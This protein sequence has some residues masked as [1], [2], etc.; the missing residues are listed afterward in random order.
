MLF[1]SR[2]AFDLGDTNR[3]VFVE[4]V[5]RNDYQRWAGPNRSMAQRYDFPEVM[6]KIQE[7][8]Q[9]RTEGEPV[10]LGLFF[11][12]LAKFGFERLDETGL[13]E[14]QARLANAQHD[15]AQ[16]RSWAAVH[17]KAKEK[18]R[19]QVRHFIAYLQQEAILPKE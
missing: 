18:L 10:V 4:Y 2:Y 5:S 19:K 6:E 13:D 8:F 14:Q 7:S 1:R 3:S 17:D 9:K 11:D 12:P 15:I 16:K